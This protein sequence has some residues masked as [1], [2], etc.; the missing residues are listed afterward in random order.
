[1]W[2]TPEYTQRV[3]V[4]VGKIEAAFSVEILTADED[5]YHDSERGNVVAF[6]PALRVTTHTSYDEAEAITIRKR[7]YTV[8]RVYVQSARGDYPWHWASRDH[9]DRGIRNDNN[10]S[11]DHSSATRKQLEELAEAA[12][13]AFIVAN[14]DWTLRSRQRRKLTDIGREEREAKNLRRTADE[15]DAKAAKLREELEALSNGE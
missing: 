14:P 9:Y 13:D 10:A 5:R 12:R 3:T 4:T 6:R 8:D 11:L 15:H 7:P 1:M 2:T